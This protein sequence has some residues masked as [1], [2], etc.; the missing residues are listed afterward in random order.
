[1]AGARGVAGIADR[2]RRLLD[3]DADIAA[4]D[5]RLRRR[6]DRIPSM[7]GVRVPGAWD[8]F[9]LCV[10]AVLGQQITVAAARTIVGRLCRQFGRPVERLAD[11][12]FTH[13][14]PT[15]EA[16]ADAPIERIGVPGKRA[17]C[18][19]GVAR[20]VAD[21]SLSLDDA[22]TSALCEQLL[23]L[24]GIG[25]WTVGYVR[26]RGFKDPDAFPAGDVAL[27]SAARALG[28]AKSR[29]ELLATA[30]G[31]RPWRAYAAVRLWRFL[32]TRR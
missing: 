14:F 12:R 31:W 2:L 19:R 9:E 13:L 24:P 25:A 29:R 4:I 3:L 8:R 1:M 18:V 6:L 5:A 26:M 20:A 32:E 17:E 23:A 10:R 11:P 27:E 16:L 30:E 28:I 15:P 21:R 7:A 22:D